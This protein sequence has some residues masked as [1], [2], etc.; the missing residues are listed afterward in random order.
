MA[1][2]SYFWG[3]TATGDATLAPYT[4]DAYSDIQRKMFQQD[5]TLEGVISQFANELAVSGVT[6][7]VAVATGAAVIDG[8]FYE[9]DASLNV[10]VPTPSTSTRLD[11]IVLRKDWTAQTIRV[12]RIAGA[13]GGGEPAIVQTDGTTW[14]VVLAKLSI[15]TGGVVALEDRR[16]FVSSPISPLR[17]T[18]PK[19]LVIASGVITVRRQ[20][21]YLIDT[22]AAASTDDLD[23]IN[24]G[25]TGQV[26]L[27]KMANSAR[28]PRLRHNVGNLK[29]S[30]GYDFWLIE[31]DRY[32]MLMFD[33][34]SWFELLPGP[35]RIVAFEILLPDVSTGEKTGINV[36]FAFDFQI[37]GGRL[38]AD[39]SGSA[40]V[41]FWVDTFANYP[42]TNADSICA[43]AKLT[44]SSVIKVED[45]TLT[46]WTRRILRGSVG[47]PEIESSSTLTAMTLVLLGTR[48]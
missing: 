35:S 36:D 13:E 18:G 5:R 22:E 46:G 48:L 14:D 20:T 21:V 9:N 8:K 41:D 16:P 47:R 3:G 19:T 28:E 17:A 2:K 15:T 27:L 6:S 43:S 39:V 29:L 40:V 45:L 7:P 10:T 33:G 1:E 4:D 34:T 30:E 44:L 25:Y 12:T 24:G 31:T 42:P 26:I 23:T 11:L 37:T 38:E 32:I